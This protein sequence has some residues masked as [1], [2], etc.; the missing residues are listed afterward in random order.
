MNRG[1]FVTPGLLVMKFGGTSVGG[2]DRISGAAALIAEA[3]RERPVVAVVSAMSKVTDALLDTMRR[4]EAGDRAGM[5]ANIAQIELRHVE[6]CRALFPADRQAPILAGLHA[7]LE[8]FR[9][10]KSVV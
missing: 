6:V 2:A 3:R 10:R 5:D 9:D 4:A 8:D 1:V 7:R